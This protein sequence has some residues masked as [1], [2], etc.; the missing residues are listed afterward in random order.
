MLDPRLPL[1]MCPESTD[2]RFLLPNRKSRVSVIFVVVCLQRMPLPRDVE[3]AVMTRSSLCH[4]FLTSIRFEEAAG[5]ATKCANWNRLPSFR[6]F[7]SEASK[8]G[9]K[10]RIRGW[11]PPFPLA[12]ERKRMGTVN[13]KAVDHLAAALRTRQHCLARCGFLLGNVF[14][15]WS[16]PSATC[17]P[18]VAVV[19]GSL[20]FSCVVQSGNYL[21]ICQFSAFQP[22]LLLSI[23]FPLCGRESCGGWRFSR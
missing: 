21:K 20:R 5:L 8:H 12:Y 22:L 6:C 4:K 9:F 14:D 19:R 13:H 1:M 16:Q 18:L 3:T 10:P 2:D 11:C 17:Q 23:D 7:D 15:R